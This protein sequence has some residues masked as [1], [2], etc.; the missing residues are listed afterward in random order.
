MRRILASLATVAAVALAGC[1][2]DLT[3][4]NN[5]TVAGAL[6]NPRA[7]VTRLVV[8]VMAT[9]RA[10]RTGE[11]RAF[12]SFGRETYYM[13]I[14][15]GRFI[16]G[17]LRDWRQNNSFDAG[18]QW[19]ARYG[20]Y[21][22]AY[23]ALKII[24]ATTALTGPEKSD[25]SGVLKTFIAL[26]MLHVIEA[27]GAIGAVVDMTDDPNAVNP[28][29]SQDSA[30]KWI[31]A[32]LDDA[33]A[34]LAAGTGGTFFFPMPFSTAG[35]SM[36]NTAGFTQFNRAIK[37]RVEAKRGSLGCG[38]ACYTTALTALTG[39]WI[40]NITVGNR[41]NGVSNI[42]ST[43][44]GDAPDD[45]GFNG[46][47]G[48]DEY[49]HPGIDSIPGVAADARYQRKVS[50]CPASSPRSEVGVN[51][52]H[53]P[54]TYATNVTPIP[55][56]RNEELVLLRAEAEWFTGDTAGAHADI[57]AVRTVSGGATPA[58][59]FATP[60]VDSEFVQ[61]LLLQRTL[62]LYQEGQR[63]PDYRRFGRLADLGKLAQDIA[64]SFTVASASVLP[65]QECDSRARAGNPG[66]IPMSCP[67][68]PA[69]P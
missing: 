26:D 19:G 5:P 25:A 3:N 24:A 63:W 12:G 44:A 14:T 51:A 9:Y 41:D 38:S 62:S 27:R 2:L 69:A 60:A 11:I 66:G 57:A 31:S 58:I 10:N 59:K 53:R 35:A 1:N 36:N 33:A 34:D 46:S 16:T 48:N 45:V 40:A 17:P 67:G 22:N 42:Y 43:A 13:F 7:A 47:T 52:T 20:N 30:Y 54:C 64:A 29:V 65:N 15:D 56:V 32:K 4:P 68:G 49:V 23:E 18:T 28:I 8:G 55:I 50:N 37:A 6:T 39:T 21:R 61:E